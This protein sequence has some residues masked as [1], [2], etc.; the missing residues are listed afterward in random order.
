MMFIRTFRLFQI[1][2]SSVLAILKKFVAAQDLCTGLPADPSS[3]GGCHCPVTD[4]LL[5]SS[6]YNLHS[7]SRRR[8]LPISHT[9]CACACSQSPPG[10][11]APAPSYTRSRWP[12]SSFLTYWSTNTIIASPRQSSIWISGML[13]CLVKFKCSSLMISDLLTFPCTYFLHVTSLLVPQSCVV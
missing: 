1:N 8:S 10:A 4:H 5:R 3:G 11:P 13:D 12:S 2:F 7:F 9:L 6:S